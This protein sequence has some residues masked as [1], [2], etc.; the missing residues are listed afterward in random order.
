M[1]A[2][3]IGEVREAY[4]WVKSSRGMPDPQ[5]EVLPVPAGLD[6]DLWLGP[7]PTRPYTKGFAPYD[8]RFWWEF[9]TCEGGNWGCHILDIP[10]WALELGHPTHVAASGPQPDADRTPQEFA[11]RMASPP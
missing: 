11:S 8:W 5:P 9:G 1:K 6:W 2:G 7:A 4:S 10:F 3:L